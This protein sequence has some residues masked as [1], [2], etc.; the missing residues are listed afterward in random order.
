[1]T[2]IDEHLEARLERYLAGE[3]TGEERS[4]FEKEILASRELAQRVYQNTNVTAAVQ[5]A[6]AAKREQEIAKRE[7]EYQRQ[8]AGVTRRWWQL[9]QVRLVGALAAMILLAAVFVFDPD[10]GGH[11]EVFRGSGQIVTA[12]EPVGEVASTPTRFVW[13]HA[14]NATSYRFELYDMSSKLQFETVTSDS[15]VS[16][17]PSAV[18]IPTGGFWVVI[19]LDENGT[20][21][22]RSVTAV[23]HAGQ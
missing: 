19:P 6:A 22:G 15:T 8:F 4:R 20:S 10:D 3:M 14:A 17:D 11:P 13:T 21:A 18:L 23:F 16:L 7:T 12:L 2:P 1:M 9:P 5:D